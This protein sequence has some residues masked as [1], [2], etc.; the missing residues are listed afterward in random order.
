M[1]VRCHEAEAPQPLGLCA[2]CALN[3]RLEIA[4]GMK[5]LSAYLAAWAAF[6]DWLRRHSRS[7]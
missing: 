4:A 1:C 6:D 5:R 3:A 2:P 7:I